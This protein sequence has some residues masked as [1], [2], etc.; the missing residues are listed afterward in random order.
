MLHWSTP[1]IRPDPVGALDIFVGL[2]LLETASVLPES[3]ALAHA[4]I[5]IFKGAGTMLE[6]V[7]LGPMP[8]LVIYGAADLLSAAIVATGQPPIIGGFKEI[9]ALV[10]FLKGSFSLLALMG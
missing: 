6:F 8:L 9:I 3:V 10:L 4:G 1:V 5:L 2:L 7:P